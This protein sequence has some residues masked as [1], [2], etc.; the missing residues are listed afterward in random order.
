MMI[1]YL[2]KG[3]KYMPSGNVV[4]VR[5]FIV[6]DSEMNAIIRAN[7]RSDYNFSYHTAEP[8]WSNNQDA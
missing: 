4:D 3:Y 1:P 5:T 6:E 8:L 7:L 2:V